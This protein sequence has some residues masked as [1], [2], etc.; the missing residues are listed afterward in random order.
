[1]GA[2][3][4]FNRLIHSDWSKSPKKRWTATAHLRDGVWYVDAPQITPSPHQFLEVLFN[5]DFKTLAGFDFPIGLPAFYLDKAGLEFRELVSTPASDRSRAFF[6]VVETLSDISL[7]QPLYRKH[8][9]GGRHAH[10]LRGLDCQKFSDLLRVCDRKTEFR[11][12]AESIFWTVGAKQVGKA[13]I[14]GWREILIPAL[15]RNALL[16]PFDG[17]LASLDSNIL[18]IAE[19]YP[20]EAYQHIGMRRIGKKRSQDGRRSSG[21]VM[22][23]WARKHEVSFVPKIEQLVAQGFSE[24]KDDEDPFDAVAGLC[25]MVE[26][27]DGRRAEAPNAM[28]LPMRR[29]GW[30]LGQVDLAVA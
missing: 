10:L 20:G 2:R 17:A 23:D 14:S 13:A 22:L 8:P 11:S 4:A 15:Q 21:A 7:G 28:N 25:G 16:W 27:A 9:S 12:R 24:S 19:T 26:V 30:I 3:L 5:D 1:M 29:E 18:T 6:A